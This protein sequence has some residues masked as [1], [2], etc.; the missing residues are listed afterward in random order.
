MGDRERP[1]C[2]APICAQLYG[3]RP[4]GEELRAQGEGIEPHSL[5][6]AL[7]QARGGLEVSGRPWFLPWIRFP[8]CHSSTA[9]PAPPAQALPGTDLSSPC[10][11]HRGPEEA[12]PVRVLKDVGQHACE[13]PAAVQDNLLLLLR[14]AAA[15]GSLHQL[16]HSL[17]GGRG[18]RW[19]GGSGALHMAQMG[20]P[21]QRGRPDPTG[22]P[23]RQGRPAQADGTWASPPFI[24]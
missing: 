7:P 24:G 1:S 6:P 23:S 19:E 10:P 13:E 22:P 5:C 21:A 14:M 18:A 11:G 15:L 17:W 12:P 2:P 8:T 9:H 16:L 20:T 3:Q 4:V